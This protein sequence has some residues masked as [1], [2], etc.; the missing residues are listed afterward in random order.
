M[1]K[2]KKVFLLELRSC[3]IFLLVALSLLS[4]LSKA[5]GLLFNSNDSLLS[6][7]T[8]Y[9]VFSND[10]PTFHDRLLIDFDL[11]LWDNDHLG[12]VFN[13]TDAKNNSYSLTYIY[14]HNG[15]PTLNF[16][17]DS[18]SNKIEIP[19]SIAQLKKR[20]W[21][22]V[23][24]DINLKNNTVAFLIN[25]K[26]YKARDF[27]FDSQM[28]P[29]V[30][31]GKNP[32]YSDVPNMAIKNLTIGDED[33]SYKFPLNEWKGTDV[34][35]T[36]GDILGHADHPV[37]L[38]NES[39]FWT[40]KYQRT[41]NEVVGLNFDAAQQIIFMFKRDSLLLYDLQRDNATSR[42]YKN[43]LPLPLLLGKSIVNTKQNKL[44]AY[45][46]QGNNGAGVA[47]L[48]LATLTW[49]T[50]GKTPIAEQRHHHNIFYDKDQNNFY[51]FGGYGSFSYHGDFFKY[52]ISS[53]TWNKALFTGD[54]INPRFFSASSAANENNDVY[55][56]GGYGNQSGNQIVGGKHYYDLY[57][58][59]LNNHTIK[60]LWEIDPQEES[61]VPANN[62]IVSRDNKYFYALCY[63]HEKPK[64][65][66]RLYKFAIADGSYEVVSGTIPVISERIESD[67]NLFF[68]PAQGEFFCT[69][70]EFSDPNRSTI[71]I[72]ALTAPPVS[73]QAYLNSQ[74]PAN[75]GFRQV[76]KYGLV[77]LILLGIAGYC[78]YRRRQRNNVVKP[79][80]ETEEESGYA[81]SVKKETE[82]KPN[83]V[84][85]LG[86]FTV[87][88]KSAR[89]ITYLFSPKIKQLFILILLNS[90]DN[91]GVV[92]KKISTT[93]WPDKD[94]ART[95]NIKGV[96]IN[97]LRNIL[98]DI[99]GI[100][101][102]FSNDTYRFKFDDSFFCDYFVVLDQIKQIT[103]NGA[104]GDVLT[105]GNAQLIGRG[106]LL[107]YLPEN[108]LDDLKLQYEELLIPVMLPEIRRIYEAGEFRKAL[109]ITRIALNID[110]FNDVALKYKLKALRRIKGVDHAR[111]VYDEFAAEYQKSLGVEYAVHFEKIC[112]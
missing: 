64:T 17:I 90:K 73:Q 8:S 52:D 65:A 109:E 25:G 39:Y 76:F 40:L 35:D 4:Q 13:I 49:N 36:D 101:L 106:S 61:F 93:L 55:I 112:K 110:P 108:W 86:E 54:K 1:G 89:D 97:H 83:S 104:S 87:Y 50:I 47:S 23:K 77:V 78:F 98:G 51:L 96:T 105:S 38:I 15:L 10:V 2:G 18:K 37:W 42:V 63:P 14:N 103:N 28:T 68:N 79:V 75:A 88:D 100:E 29:K 62:L 70:E 99:E 44:Y 69:T 6:Q 84:Y 3:I 80:L 26:W 19:L 56:F 5:Q 30:T 71:K 7:R 111:K 59:N 95:K 60:K 45:E 91:I 57:R 85:L 41:F 72:F 34:H 74:K 66:L 24:A 92:S 67:I 94:V 58:V 20:N 81:V 27:G 53:G 12:Y 32:H 16:N 31:F 33:K 107:Q 21:F 43:K 22:K 11:S 9:T 102:T 46:V 48:D 82:Q